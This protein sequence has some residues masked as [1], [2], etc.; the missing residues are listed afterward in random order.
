[1]VAITSFLAVIACSA[2][3]FK[4][5]ETYDFII[6]GAGSAGSVVA[7]RLSEIPCVSV[8]LLEAG[9][10][11]PLVTDIPGIWPDLWRTDIDWKYETVPQKE[12]A[13]SQ[14]NNQLIYPRGKT[15]GGTSVLN[16]ML[17]TRCSRK[18]YDGWA[19]QGALGWSSEDVWPYFYKLE[20]NQDK[21]YLETGY[22]VRG[23]PQS[24]EKIKYHPE[25]EFPLREAAEKL[26]FEFID[27][28][29]NTQSKVYDYQATIKNGQRSSTAKSYLVPA[30]NRTNLNIVTNAF[31]KKILLENGRAV[32]VVFDR[33]GTTYEVRA[34]KE[35]VLSAGAINTPQLLM[36]SGIGPQKHLEDLNIP[37]IKDLPVGE[38]LQDHGTVPLFYS[39]DQSIPSI[40]QKLKDPLNVQ[41][42]IQNRTGP[43]AYT[44]QFKLVPKTK[45]AKFPKFELY[46]QE[47]LASILKPL[48][49]KEEVYNEV[50]APFENLT[51]FLCSSEVLQPKSRGTVKLKSSDPYDHPLIDPN[52]LENPQDIEDTVEGLKACNSIITGD[53]MQKI[54]SKRYSIPH[55]ECKE[56]PIESDNYYRCLTH[57]LIL[58]VYHPV[59]TAKMG[60]PDD[61]T[62][63]V[64]HQLRV[65]G[66]EGLRV[67]D[68]SI[69][70]TLPSGN[71]NVPTIMIGEKA[72]DIIKNTLMCD[73]NP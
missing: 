5:S 63:V 45:G 44:L 3:N 2:E 43:I 52:F 21:E 64:D 23:G 72:S 30:E 49:I 71:T 70:P 12:T 18:D 68:A 50:Y 59:G 60:H 17:Y 57:S 53:A 65:K 28:N 37:L 15:L 24:A 54:H 38:N 39:V 58:T 26:G 48:G 35:V 29:G 33:K 1:M 73:Y 11:P 36:L 4:Q 42:Y 13:A 6:V 8:L 66:I 67:V 31:V 51:S 9:E 47:L 19:A 61:P 41:R 56:F 27:A 62:T 55:P 25:I 40:T 46:F 10:S 20:D 14:K 69:M 32:G 34:S 22:H 7:N 16:G